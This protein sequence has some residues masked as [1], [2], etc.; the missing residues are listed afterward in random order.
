MVWYYGDV[1]MDDGAE[2]QKG[3]MDGSREGIDE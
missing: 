3:E 1:D 2:I